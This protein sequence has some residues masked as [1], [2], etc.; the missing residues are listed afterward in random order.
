MSS[1]NLAEIVHNNW[2]QQSSNRGKDLYVAIVDDFVRALLQVSRYYQFL[3][4]ELIRTGLG[5]E[6]LMLRVGQHSAQRSGNPKVLNVA[7]VK[8]CGAAKFYTPGPH[9][10]GE[11]VFGS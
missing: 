5:K 7:I 9:F 6:E 1:C 11:E 8:M 2:L 10:E 3:K 4:G